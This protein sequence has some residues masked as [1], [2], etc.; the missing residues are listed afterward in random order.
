MYAFSQKEDDQELQHEGNTNEAVVREGCGETTVFNQEHEGENVH[1]VQPERNTDEA[2]EVV[3][4]L[5]SLTKN[6]RE[7]MSKRCN[8]KETLTTSWR[9]CVAGTIVFN[10]EP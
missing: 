9:L 1:E 7:R 4:G 6:L 3:G 2:M 8:P 10:Q 5:L